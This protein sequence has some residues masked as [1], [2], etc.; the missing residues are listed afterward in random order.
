MD[1]FIGHLIGDY[2]FQNDWMGENKKKRWLPALVHCAVYTACVFALTAIFAGWPWWTIPIIFLSHL[3][4]DK[5]ML[6]KYL[7]KVIRREGFIDPQSIFFPWSWVI[8]DN[9][10]HLVSLYALGKIVQNLAV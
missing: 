1:W 10:I 4:V 3:A 5:T 2:L 9:T 7:A 8:I 6:V